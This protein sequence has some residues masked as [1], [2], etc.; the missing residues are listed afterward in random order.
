M[1][2]NQRFMTTII[3]RP[4]GV[5]D[6]TTWKKWHARG[7]DF[8]GYAWGAPPN[9]EPTSYYDKDLAITGEAYRAMSSGRKSQEFNDKL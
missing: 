6:P 4:D 1:F 2:S 3:G 7:C 9:F 5:S 8:L